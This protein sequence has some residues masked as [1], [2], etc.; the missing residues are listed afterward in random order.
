MNNLKPLTIETAPEG[1]KAALQAIQRGFGFIPNLMATFANSPAVLD[2]Y[3]A[4][5]HAWEKSSLSPSDRQLI[6]LA[7]SV[8]N[9]CRYCTAAHST[10]LKGMMKVDAKIVQ[11]IRN[12]VSIGDSKKDALVAAVRELVSER[13][14]ISET[15]QKR[16]FD[17]GYTPVQL[18]EVLIGLAL[19]TVSNYLDHFNPTEVDAAFKENA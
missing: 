19:K 18:M 8:E 14:Q 6:L 9:S 7:V 4:M 15:T 5:D 3:M 13:G 16:F 11:A 17:N 10:I 12:R 1:S 2:G